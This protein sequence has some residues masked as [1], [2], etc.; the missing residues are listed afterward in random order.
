MRRIAAS[1]AL[2][3]A[4]VVAPATAGAQEKHEH[5]ANMSHVKNLPYAAD[6]GGTPN[7]GTDI[8]FATLAGSK[9]ALAGSSP[10]R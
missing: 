1:L 4:L 10:T 8:E 7:Y 3:A 5:S 2:L 6:N 9:Y